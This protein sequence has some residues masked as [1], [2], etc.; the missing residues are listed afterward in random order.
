MDNFYR[1]V[2]QTF[3]FK[4]AIVITVVC[5]FLIGILWGGSIGTVVYAIV[6]ISFENGTFTTWIDKQ[7]EQIHNAPPKEIVQTGWFSD[8]S[9]EAVLVYLRPYIE[10]YTPDTPFKTVVFLLAFMLLASTLRS[11]CVVCQTI[12]S[13]HIAQG[14]TLFIREEFFRNVIAY[15]VNFF[16]NSGVADTMSRFT[17][18]MSSLAGGFDILYGK[19]VR[20]PIKMIVC[21]T[22]AAWISWQLLFFTLLLLPI[23]VVAIRWLA[24]SIKRAVRRGMEEMA[25]MYS[26]L[27]ET[28][29]SVKIV[30]AFTREIYERHKFHA[31]NKAYYEKSM[32][33]TKYSS[34]TNP[35]TELLGLLMISVAILLGA[36]LLMCPEQEL[37]KL[38]FISGATLDRGL[39][40]AFF[41]LLAAAADPARKLADIF[42]QFQSAVAAADRIY[43]MIDRPIIIHD[44]ENPLPFERHH[45]SITFEDVTFAY[46]HGRPVLNNVSLRIEYGETIAIVGQSGCGKSTLVSLVLRFIDPICGIVKIDGVPVNE[47]R[48]TDL[49]SQIGLVTQ[50]PTLFNETVFNNIKYGKPDATREEVINAAQSA[51]AH[52][53]I[54]K[55]LSAGYET[56]VGPGGGLLS[57]GQRQRIALARAILRDPTIL[58][59]DEATSQVD[60]Y[61]EQMIHEALKS[62]VGKRTTLIVTH[63]PSALSLANRIVVMCDGKIESV[64]T[65]SELLKNSP[66]Y[67]LLYH[68]D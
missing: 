11:I 2:R 37:S 62:F 38:T 50:E 18:D 46:E 64:G 55:E 36:Y 3:R 8:A 12:A 29:R 60:M 33:I 65:H 66:T 31:T 42:T 41:G 22:L 43:A 67:L 45:K 20:E 40:L 25:A 4:G 17:N 51:F 13:A 1:A 7:I 35:L 30:K 28:F 21:L 14:G 61:S 58:L 39:L 44:P 54:E 6:E 56:V 52:E 5:A 49:R 15:E 47:I 26:R 57:G 24:R 32:K 34:L 9:K 16:N 19:L 63:R 48:Q 23:A 68:Q 10:R 27:E 53:F 59:L